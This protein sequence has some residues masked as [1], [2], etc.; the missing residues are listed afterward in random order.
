MTMKVILIKDVEKLGKRGD[1][2]EVRDGYARNYLFPNK[3]ALPGTPANIRGLEKTRKHFSQGI[4]RIRKMSEEVAEKLNNLSIKTNIKVGIDGKSFGSI[5]P[6]NI[7]ELLKK[8]KIEIDK[9]QIVL[10]GPIKH[11]GV[12]D[13]T[14]R[15]PQQVVAVFKLVVTEEE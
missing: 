6:Q 10:D 4:E 8:E 7:V 1:V 2:V 5:N 12:Y 15:L 9:K 14:V 3:M 11:P 13:I